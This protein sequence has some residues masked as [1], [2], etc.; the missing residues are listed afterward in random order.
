MDRP[1][2][3]QGI[4]LQFLTALE[5]GDEVKVLKVRALGMPG[6]CEHAGRKHADA[7]VGH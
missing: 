7:C 1:W 3:V 5:G 4:F 2:I 6:P